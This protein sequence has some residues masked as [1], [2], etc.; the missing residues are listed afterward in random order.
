V[1]F[2]IEEYFACLKLTPAI[3]LT[4][5][6]QYPSAAST[7]SEFV[8]EIEFCSDILVRLSTVVNRNRFS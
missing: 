8:D 7:L 6:L 1:P 4:Y 2:L 5:L 3:I